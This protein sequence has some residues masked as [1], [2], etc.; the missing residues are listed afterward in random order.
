M[1]ASFDIAI[2]GASHSGL[3][4]ALAF[5]RRLGPGVRIAL[6]ERTGPGGGAA[7][8]IR[9]FALSAGTVR[10]FRALGAWPALEA[11]AEPIRAIEIT[12][13]A[14]EHAIRPVL[15]TYDNT[16]GPNEP[17]TVI[18]EAEAIRRALLAAV[19]AIPAITRLP[20]AA[21]M[22]L[23]REA[24]HLTVRLEGGECVSAGLL[25][26][27]DGRASSVRDA[28]GIKSVTWR[29]GQ[30]GI[31]TTVA[32]EHPHQG[33]AV[34]HF[35]P[36]GPFALLPLPRNRSCI[37]WTERDEAGRALVAGPDDVFRAAIEKRLDY[38]LG[39]LESIG[40]RGVWPLEPRIA[41]TLIADRLALIGDAARTVLPLAGQGLNLAFRDVAALADCVFEA[42]SVGLAPGDVTALERY[43][44]WRRFDSASA[45]AAFAALDALFSNDRTLLR[46]LRG[47]WLGLVD[48]A[49]GLKSLL[50]REA[51][52]LTGDLPSLMQAPGS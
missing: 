17:A 38:R 29:T 9:A 35:L 36:S 47:A 1:T 50:V 26:G 4:M 24:G 40:P 22:G 3:A 44:R 45:S 34:Q 21:I 14:L 5:A 18:A 41:R 32:H 12:D 28:A 20:E 43:E 33:R 8:D 15:L 30:V 19:E 25:V 42:M 51:A 13:S 31:V 16:A 27:A 48:R 10:L 49:P 11:A 52:G 39:R 46:A 37:T 2:A 23:E 6:I 7:P